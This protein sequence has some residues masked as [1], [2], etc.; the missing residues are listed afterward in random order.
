MSKIMPDGPRPSQVIKFDNVA[1][2][3]EQPQF[4]SADDQILM[5]MRDEIVNAPNKKVIYCQI[6]E[7]VRLAQ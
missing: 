6:H 7:K 5:D 1:C 4:T 2:Q 3:D